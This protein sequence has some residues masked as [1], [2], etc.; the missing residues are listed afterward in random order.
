MSG[1]FYI[2]R[3]P[4]CGRWS[5]QEIRT[6]VLDAIFKCKYCGKTTKVKQKRQFGLSMNHKGPFSLPAEA[7]VECQKMN[8]MMHHGT[9]D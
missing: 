5:V 2:F 8:G 3:C 4:G 7:T 1:S 9:K 6:T